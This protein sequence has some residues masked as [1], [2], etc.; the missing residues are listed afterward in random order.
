[1]TET[2]PRKGD[3]IRLHIDDLAYGG[4]GLAR[5]EDFVWFV[6]RAIPGQTVLAQVSRRCKSYGEAF[7]REVVEESEHWTEPACPHFGVCGGCKLQHL[8]YEKQLEAKTN[9]VVDLVSRLG[10]VKDIPMEPSLPALALYR[11]RNKMEF[12]FSDNPWLLP[13]DQE[14]RPEMVLGLHVPR[15]FD[16]VLEIDSC[17]LQSNLADQVLTAVRELSLNSGL[18]PYNLRWHQGFFR[19]LVLR[20]GSGSGD[21][22][23][24]LV[25]SGQE[26]SRGDQEVDLIAERLSARI[27]GI[28][29]FVHS[30]SDR[31]AQAAFSERSRIIFGP[32]IIREKIGECIF[33]ISPDAFFQTNTRQTETLFNSIAR[34]AG[35]S[36]RETVYDLYCGTGAIGIF[37]AGRARRVL[38]IEVIESAVR[39]ARRNA[40]IN[41]LENIEFIQ[42]DMKDA[43]RE[44]DE[45][46]GKFGSPDLVILDPP[47]GGTHPK[48]VTDLVT[49]QAPRLIYVSCNPSIL[50]RDLQIL[51]GSGYALT[52]LQPVDMFPHTAHIESVALLRWDG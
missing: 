48:T 15:R 51:R 11:Y 23:V 38:G 5:R 32:G 25:T 17:R 39:D 40:A 52:A 3:I 18:S 46:A 19:F 24:N 12:T 4:R 9:Q 31:L 35:L 33:Q 30:I 6:E 42:A 16:K 37:L 45:L 27:P 21:F 44:K 13:G 8:V 36:G 10:G 41:R 1:M 50:A 2:L 43:I 26:G 14:P 49:L 34:L 29:T 22:M 7:L 28:T 47:R 20:E